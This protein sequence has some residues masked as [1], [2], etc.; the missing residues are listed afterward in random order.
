[1][2]SPFPPLTATPFGSRKITPSGDW[3]RGLLLGACVVRGVWREGRKSDKIESLLRYDGERV[4][5]PLLPRPTLLWSG[6]E[7]RPPSVR[8]VIYLDIRDTAVHLNEG[9]REGWTGKRG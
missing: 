6:L 3:E 8:P 9:G 7:V 5:A 4:V 2:R 1:M